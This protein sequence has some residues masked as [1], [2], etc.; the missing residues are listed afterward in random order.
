M[1]SHVE[2]A[3]TYLSGVLRAPVSR[4]ASTTALLRNLGTATLGAVLYGVGLAIF[5]GDPLQVTASALKMPL[6]LLG[7]ALLC[8]PTFHLVQTSHASHPLSLQDA[9][10]TMSTAL[11]ATGFTWAAL[12]P[13]VLFLVTTSHDY[14]LARVIAVLVGAAGGIV[15]LNRFRKLV[16][17]LNQDAPGPAMR[18]S[19]W[20]FSLLFSMVG[21]QLA[22]VLRPFIGSPY[23]A[24]TWFRELGSTPITFLLGQ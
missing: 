20:L 10:R 23:M 1:S 11:A 7:T 9:L 13:P 18:R 2:P 19:L 3:P 21:L 15:G 16:A 24:F 5:S 14:A 12:S 8:F 17:Q 6:L 22:W 4:R